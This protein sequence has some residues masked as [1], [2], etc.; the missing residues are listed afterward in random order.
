MANKLAKD[1]NAT[2]GYDQDK[3][4]SR[5]TY[6]TLTWVGYGVG[7]ACLVGG[8][9]L[10]YLGSR[11][12]EPSTVALLPSLAPGQAGVNLQGAF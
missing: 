6:A 8:A 10:Y 11:T 7:G 1:L 9:I 12:S 2:G 3:A 5:S 4:S